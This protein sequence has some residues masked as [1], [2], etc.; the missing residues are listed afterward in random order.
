MRAFRKLDYIISFLLFLTISLVQVIKFDAKT[1]IVAV[2][3][4]LIVS[5]IF[6]TITNVIFKRKLNN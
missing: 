5:F 3:V 4:S 6:G 2:V 1:V